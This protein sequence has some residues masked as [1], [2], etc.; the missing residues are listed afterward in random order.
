MLLAREDAIL[1]LSWLGSR[2]PIT[3][4]QTLANAPFMLTEPREGALATA[5]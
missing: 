2:H 5:H 4:P 1:P 3:T